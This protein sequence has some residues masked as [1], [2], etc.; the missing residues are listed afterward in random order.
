MTIRRTWILVALATGALLAATGARAWVAVRVGP[1]L[2]G[3]A[4]VGVAAG[5]VAGAAVAS[6]SSYPYPS[7]VVVTP[8]PAPPPPAAAAPPQPQAA[9]QPQAPAAPQAPPQP[10][11]TQPSPKSTA[12][13]APGTVVTSLPSGCVSSG[14]RYQCGSVW[15]QPY[16]G[17]NGVYFEVVR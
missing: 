12:P 13:P 16:F 15:Y 2:V 3:A 6:A 5:A 14:G 11:A 10:Q 9:P 17:A 4:A 7:T 1:R 8:P